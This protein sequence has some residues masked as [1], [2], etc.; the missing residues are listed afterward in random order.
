MALIP[1]PAPDKQ[2]R[3]DEL[4]TLLVVPLLLL[5]GRKGLGVRAG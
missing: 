4:K 5:G 1:E 3:G 2:E